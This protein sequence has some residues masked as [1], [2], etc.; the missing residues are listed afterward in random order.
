MYNP[1]RINGGS[2]SASEL[3]NQISKP[4][5]LQNHGG[6]GGFAVRFRYGCVILCFSFLFISSRFFKNYFK[7]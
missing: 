6:Q 7:S 1:Q 5:P 3:Q 4:S 2:I